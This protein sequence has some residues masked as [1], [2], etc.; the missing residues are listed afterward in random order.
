MSYTIEKLIENPT[1]FGK[2]TDEQFDSLFKIVTDLFACMDL[3]AMGF[4]CVCKVPSDA[5][6]GEYAYL[7]RNSESLARKLAMYPSTT[8]LE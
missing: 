6:P 5:R 8:Y 4:E 2:L 3:I 1:L 7:F